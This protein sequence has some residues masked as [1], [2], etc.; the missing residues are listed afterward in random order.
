MNDEQ[1]SSMF[2]QWDFTK[3]EL[4]D[5]TQCSRAEQERILISKVSEQ[6][7]TGK[8]QEPEPPAGGAGGGAGGFGGD[9]GFS[10]VFGDVFG[11]GGGR[12]GGSS[13]GH[14]EDHNEDQFKI[15]REGLEEEFGKD[16]IEEMLSKANNNYEQKVAL[17]TLY[18]DC[19][20]DDPCQT[21]DR[22]AELE[23]CP[24]VAGERAREFGLVPVL[25]DNHFKVLCEMMEEEFGKDKIDGIRAHNDRPSQERILVS[26]Y[27]DC[28]SDDPCQTPEL[29]DN[30][31]TDHGCLAAM[32]PEKREAIRHT[33]M[34]EAGAQ[35]WERAKN[36]RKDASPVLEDEHFNILCH[37]LKK[38]IKEYNLLDDE[39]RASQER[40]LVSVKY[41]CTSDAYACMTP[42]ICDNRIAEQGCQAGMDLEKSESIKRAVRNL[43][44]NDKYCTK[45]GGDVHCDQLGCHSRWHW[46]RKCKFASEQHDSTK[47]NFENTKELA[48]VAHN[49]KYT[50][51]LKANGI[52]VSRVKGLFESKKNEWKGEVTGDWEKELPQK[53][54]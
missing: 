9:A 43:C 17:V 19:L 22:C 13:R 44:I 53:K 41:N 23:G 52:N 29:C 26:V 48:L 4:I 51:Y 47:S 54:R 20:S 21:P 18:H 5:F 50:E 12:R 3:E 16:K 11:G 7:H 6:V 24:S 30:R 39:D 31:I 49:G 40:M 27:H 2:Q 35:E 33:V 46:E 36:T 10:D 25:G 37:S 45:Q 8:S 42:E 15:I 34:T 38:E 1:F 32:N 28:V 14:N